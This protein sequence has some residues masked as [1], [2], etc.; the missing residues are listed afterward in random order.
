MRSAHRHARGGHARRWVAAGVVGLLGVATT[1]LVVLVSSGW[2]RMDPILSGS[3]RPAFPVGGVVVAER[4]PVSSIRVGDVVLFSPPWAAGE[5]YV[6]RIIGVRR[7]K[8]ATTIRTKGDANPVPDP[9]PI[10]LTGQSIYEARFVVPVLGYVAVWSHSP[11]GELELAGAALAGAL[12]VAGWVGRQRR[13]GGVVDD[14]D[15]QGVQVAVGGCP[16]ALHSS[17][18]GAY[19]ETASDGG[20]A[21]A[22]AGSAAWFDLNER[23]DA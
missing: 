4:V 20:R 1:A 23:A 12:V 6:H 9:A 19:T 3:M 8:G 16:C 5:T 17:R 15:A 2:W 11:E 14:L 13:R 10:R 21:G 18:T 7:T 22:P